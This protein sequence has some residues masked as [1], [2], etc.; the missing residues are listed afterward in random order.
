MAQTCFQVGTDKYPTQIGNKVMKSSTS[1]SNLVLS[2]TYKGRR[3]GGRPQSGAR[4]ASN[5]SYNAGN[6][7]TQQ[8]PSQIDYRQTQRALSQQ[9]DFRVP[10][11]Q[12]VIDKTGYLSRILKM[13]PFPLVSFEISAI[14]LQKTLSCKVSLFTWFQNQ[15][16]SFF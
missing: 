13:L 2:Y 11:Q 16:F 6:R 4:P 10:S 3:G 1:T 15:N 5:A 7:P 9:S 14:Q 8:R 12:Q